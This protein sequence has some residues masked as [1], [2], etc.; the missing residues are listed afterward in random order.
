MFAMLMLFRSEHGA[1]SKNGEPFAIVPHAMATCQVLGRWDAHKYRRI[2]NSL[3][4][5]G[6]IKMIAPSTR[7]TPAL[8]LLVSRKPT[9]SVKAREERGRAAGQS[10]SIGG[11]I[12]PSEIDKTLH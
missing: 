6:F 9:L 1:R 8:Y 12:T 2:R 10:S 11:Q 4:E 3:L 7:K 5:Y